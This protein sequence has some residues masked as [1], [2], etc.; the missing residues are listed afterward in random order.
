MDNLR[1]LYKNI[2][3]ILET[4]IRKLKECIEE[5]KTDYQQQDNKLNVIV[6][7]TANILQQYEFIEYEINTMKKKVIDTGE[8]ITSATI[9]KIFSIRNPDS[10]IIFI[11]KIMYE[12]LKNNIDYVEDNSNV[13]MNNSNINSSSI[14]TSN[15]KKEKITWEF[16]K[17]N[18]TYKSILLLLSF[19]SETSNLNLSKDIME[20]AKPIITKSNHYKDC[21]IN[22]F[23]EIIA[24]IDFIKILIVY[25][26]KLALVKKLYISNKKKNNKMEAIQLDLDKHSQLIQKAKILLNE[27]S[28]DFNAL[29]K[30][31]DINNKVIYGYNILEKYSLYE[32]YTVGKE[33]IYNYDAEYYNNYGGSDYNNKVTK[34]KYVIKLNKKYRNKEKFIQQLS[35]SLISYTKGIRKINKEKFIQNIKDNKNN[36]LNKNS[37]TN[38]KNKN[39]NINNTSISMNNNI[40]KRSIE[41]NNSSANLYKSFQ[42]NSFVNV[43]RNNSNP[44]RSENSR[45]NIFLIKSFV[46]SYPTFDNFFQLS[47][48]NLLLKDGL[49]AS[50]LDWEQTKNSTKNN[51]NSREFNSLKNSMN[52]KII[53][54]LNKNNNI[55]K[56]NNT[57]SNNN[58]NKNNLCF[59]NLKQQQI[60]LKF[61]NEQW[62]PC[63]LC[64]KTIKNKFNKKTNNNNK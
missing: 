53:K 19:F 39:I 59:R 22:T 23:P 16:L 20:N 33:N 58:K 36:S 55:N 7:K 52:Q 2:N 44:Y 54:K 38:S 5:F 21:Y 29:K 11:M 37:N 1:I 50:S 8:K 34:I 49:N 57:Y 61:E 13:N 43:T 15:F 12:I 10:Q 24:I 14:N 6:E 31:K 60:N 3:L 51:I 48:R 28:K 62:S 56:I 63:S 4:E 25:Y 47:N 35:S 45:N 30:N 46:D 18:I 64:C 42:N 32:K 40:L 27:V 26:T 9:N 17:I 41:S